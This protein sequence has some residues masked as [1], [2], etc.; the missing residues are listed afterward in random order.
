MHIFVMTMLAMPHN[1]SDHAIATRVWPH[2]QTA[3][4]KPCW[5][6]NMQD[7]CTHSSHPQPVHLLDILELCVLCHPV[8]CCCSHLDRS[9]LSSQK[10]LSLTHQGQGLTQT[11][12][13]GPTDA[14]LDLSMLHFG[15]QMWQQQF[16]WTEA[17]KEAKLV[18]R[19]ALL[20]PTDKLAQQPLFCFE[21]MMHLIYF[22]CLV[23]DYKRV[24]NIFRFCGSCLTDTC[25]NKHLVCLTYD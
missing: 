2:T 3:V 4:A 6:C 5:G 21:T 12:L 20:P 17:G 23:Y 24:R 25:V 18:A 10:T 15:L 14:Q 19:S 11:A 8:P 7:V 1:P 22:S 13:S 16:A 9:A